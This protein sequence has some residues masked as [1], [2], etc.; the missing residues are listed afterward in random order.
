MTTGK[1]TRRSP[2]ERRSEI[3]EAA[4]KV[5]LERGYADVGLTEIAAAGD[6]SRGL[7]Y[8]Y[9]PAG[10]PD[11]YMAVAEGILGE[12]QERLRYAA[13][14]P[15]SP[16]KRMEHLLAALFAFFQDQPAAFRFLFRDVWAARD[17][18]I[19]AAAIAARAPMAAEIASLVAMAGP[20][21]A[22]EVT[23]TSVGILGFALANIELVL[24]QNADP[25]TAWR[26][27]CSF[28]TA[29]LTKGPGN[30]SGSSPGNGAGAGSASGPSAADSA[31]SPSS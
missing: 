25:E 16:A 3:V 15:F 26:V 24:N 10:R 4:R 29:H 14:A 12:L 9:F 7:V 28:A 2:D 6:V 31:D 27:T 19:E 23:A 1:R 22:D 20:R 13:S 30:G 18:S 21:S 17:E 11:L 8:R 5:F